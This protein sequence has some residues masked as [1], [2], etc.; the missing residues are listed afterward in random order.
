MMHLRT[1]L[2]AVFAALVLVLAALP[3]ARAT[4]EHTYGKREYAVIES[5]RAPNGKLSIAAH[6][7]GEGGHDKF[8]VYLM[9]EPGHRKLAVLDNISED[10]NLDTA[11]DAYWAAW[12]PDSRYVAVT[13]R[14]ERHIVTLNLYAIEDSRAKLLEAPDLFRDVTGRGTDRKTD[15]DMRSFVPK[16]E[17]QGPRRFRFTDYRL[18]VMDDARLA[19]QLGALGKPEKMD[20]GRYSIEFSAQAD[21]EVLPTNRLRVAKPQPGKFGEP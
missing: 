9:A 11:P 10:N 14:S 16:L 4:A 15:G 21:G 3:Q 19:D 6:G 18:F 12:S 5:G 8:H 20:D 17:W 2:A 7:E 1:M 13:F